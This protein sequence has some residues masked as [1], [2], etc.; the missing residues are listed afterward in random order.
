[1]TVPTSGICAV[2]QDMDPAE[3]APLFCVGLT[4]YKAMTRNTVPRGSLVAVHGVGGLGHLAIQYSKVMGYRTRIY[5]DES[6]QDAVQELQKL[7]GADMI[8][9]T[10]PNAA[11]VWNILG[12]LGYDGKLVITSVPAEPAFLHPALLCMKR[13]VIVGE[14]VGDA[15]DCAETIAFS[16]THGI[17]PM[18][19]TFPLDKALEAFDHRP[20]ARFR[21]VVLPW[22]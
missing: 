1:M 20:K 3:A 15:N 2:P 16:N 12:G 22:A 18:V 11:G 4:V 7:G 21:S 5:I 8:I 14:F 13:L 9:T 19:E 10:V 17:K 6:T